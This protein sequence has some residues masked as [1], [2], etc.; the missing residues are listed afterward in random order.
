MEL[1]P[2]ELRMLSHILN[3][4]RPWL[5]SRPLAGLGRAS[6]KSSPRMCA[7]GGSPRIVLDARSSLLP[8]PNAVLPIRPT[9]D[10]QAN[11]RAG[12]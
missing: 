9:C 11:D 5:Y 1:R 7:A 4:D 10:A 8:L 2:I 3:M 12:L 6:P